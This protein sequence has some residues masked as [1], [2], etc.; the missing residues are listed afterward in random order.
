MNTREHLQEEQY[1]FPYHH[2][3]HEKNGGILIFRHL[4][5]GLAHYTYLQ[6]VLSKIVSE[7]FSSL[8]DVG[9]GEGRIIA[10]LEHRIPEC[11]Y[12]GIDISERALHFA[13]GFSKN[14]TFI[15]HNIAER[16]TE[17]TYHCAVSC[18]VIEHIEPEKISSYVRNIATSL[19][20]EGTLFLTTPTTNIPVIP[21]HYQH[22]TLET[23]RSH[24]EPYFTIQETYYLNKE[25]VL[26]SIL[27]RILANRIYISNCS[28][29]N[30]TIS[31]LY[32]K[33]LLIGDSKSG[34][35]IFVIASK[36]KLIGS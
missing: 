15:V 5:W 12:T 14:S 7:N 21:K 1:H 18:E 8:I 25:G 11:K 19:D 35:R 13:R 10:E 34:T 22:F 16:P 2:L 31:R 27:T 20:A 24:L 9:C 4:F 26:Y 28:W 17:D 30:A 32:K 6:F 33:F 29:I 3:T 23:L 36:N